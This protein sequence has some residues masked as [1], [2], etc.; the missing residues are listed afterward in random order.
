MARFICLLGLVHLRSGWSFML[1]KTPAKIRM[2][3][4]LYSPTVPPILL[5]DCPCFQQALGPARG[6]WWPQIALTT[7][8]EDSSDA[9]FSSG[10]LDT[11]RDP[12]SA[13]FYSTSMRL[14]PAAEMVS[15]RGIIFRAAMRDAEDGTE[16]LD[17]YLDRIEGEDEDGDECFMRFMVAMARILMFGF[18]QKMPTPSSTRTR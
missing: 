9:R 4:D 17:D 14:E 12:A 2:V 11:I 6:E 18:V 13:A 5:A 7:P 3:G 16:A 1:P 10:L 15:Q 8:R